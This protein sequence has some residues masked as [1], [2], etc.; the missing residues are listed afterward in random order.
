MRREPTKQSFKPQLLALVL[1]LALL[2]YAINPTPTPVSRIKSEGELPDEKQRELEPQ[3]QRAAALPLAF[4]RSEI[5][6]T[7]A[8]G[9]DK[10]EDDFEWPEY[11]DA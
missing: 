10:D 2:W 8:F 7:A 6:T 9:L 4:E 5:G 1:A 11:I 3:L